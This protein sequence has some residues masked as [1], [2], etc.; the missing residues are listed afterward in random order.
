[1]REKIEMDLVNALVGL[2]EGTLSE[3]EETELFQ[4]LV[5]TGLAW[6][7]QGRIGRLAADMIAAGVVTQ[8]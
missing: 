5:D 6:Q 7:L 8:R 3:E 1:M 2:D 4:H